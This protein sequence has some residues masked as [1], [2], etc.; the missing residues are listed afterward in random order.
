MRPVLALLLCVTALLP[1]ACSSKGQG[2][3]NRVTFVWGKTADSTKLDPAVI[4]DGES[5]TV[6]SNLFD[7]LVAL[8]EGGLDLVPWLA[9]SW[10]TSKDGL[11]WT[12]KLRDDVKFHDGSPFNAE[13][14]VF[15]YERQKDAERDQHKEEDLEGFLEV[16]WASREKGRRCSGI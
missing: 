15:S 2:S 14:V 6:T 11:H 4:T 1:A 5:V 7:G 16:H 10:E 13:A 9:T 8:E 12:F 3:A